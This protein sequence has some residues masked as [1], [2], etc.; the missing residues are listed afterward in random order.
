[1]FLDRVGGKCRANPLPDR[2]TRREQH[3][4]RRVDVDSV[5]YAA[6]QTPF[7]DPVGFGRTCDQRIEQGARFVDSQRMHRYA[8]RF[9]DREPARALCQHH[10]RSA[11]VGQR[12]FILGSRK[13]SH[14]DRA[15]LVQI[16]A[17]RGLIDDLPVD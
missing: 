16:L 17:L 8:G 1:M 9:V 12:S 13:R 14:R 2:F 15:A 6:S 4:A 3:H 7:A 11:R 10:E 5:D